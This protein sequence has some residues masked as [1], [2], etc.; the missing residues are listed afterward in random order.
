M[1]RPRS[2]ASVARQLVAPGLVRARI[3]RSRRCSARRSDSSAAR[4]GK[5]ARG[6]RLPSAPALR[7][8]AGSSGKADVRLRHDL[9][10]DVLQLGR[11]PGRLLARPRRVGLRRSRASVACRVARSGRSCCLRRS[12]L[13]P[14]ATRCQSFA[15]A[16]VPAS[17]DR[18]VDRRHDRIAPPGAAIRLP[19]LGERLAAQVRADL[20]QRRRHLHPAVGQHQQGRRRLF[21]ALAQARP[22]YRTEYSRVPLPVQ[23]PRPR[24]RGRRGTRGTASA[25]GSSLSHRRAAV[26]MR[27]SLPVLKR[28]APSARARSMTAR[29]S[30]R[31]RRV[32]R[33]GDL[34][35]QSGVAHGAARGVRLGKRSAGALALVDLPGCRR[36]GLSGSSGSAAARAARRPRRRSAGRWSRS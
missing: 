11:L 12:G 3:P 2:S 35:R 23:R 9:L 6:T 18:A 36:R 32:G 16:C 22:R 29:A 10:R 7:K 28:N 1:R 19:G 4:Q 31:L 20:R 30:W 15:S 33:E 8:R 14:P 27:I 21:E 13:R 5:G 26:P 34:E 17:L 24:A 25:D